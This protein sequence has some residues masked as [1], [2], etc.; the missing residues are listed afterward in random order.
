MNR[1]HR[2]FCRSSYWSRRLESELIPWALRDLDLGSDLLEVGSGPGL[3]TDILRRSF[4]NITAIEIDRRLAQSLERR[5]ENTNVRVLNADATRMPLPDSTFSGAVSFTMLHHV[6]SPGLQ[7]KLLAEV[8]RVLKPGGTFAGTDSRWSRLFQ[9]MHIADTMVLVDPDTFGA[10]LEKA[11]FTGTE[12]R[13]GE[14]S[15]RFR[16]TRPQ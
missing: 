11:G 16:A 15:F 3:T 10:R 12:I 4:P 7:D 13:V 5:L 14:R 9:F 2:M 6:P 1:F 8:Y